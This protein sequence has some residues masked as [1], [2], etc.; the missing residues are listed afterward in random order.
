[1]SVKVFDILKWAREY[2]EKRNIGNADTD[3]KILLSEILGIPRL[4]LVLL[5]DEV[6]NKKTVLKFK[7]YI[8]RHAGYEPVAYI[9]GNAEFM[10]LK[11]ITTRQV[12]IPR[13][14]TEILAEEVIKKIKEKKLKKAAVLDIG[15][16]SGAVA[17]SVAAYVK[18]AKL[19]AVDK[20]ARALN[21]AAKNAAINGIKKSRIKFL[22]SDLFGA[23]KKTG[24]K[25][26][27]IVSNPPYIAE[28]EL[29]KLSLFVKKYEP[30]PALYGGKD[31]LDVIRK[32]IKGSCEYLKRGGCL[33]LETG[34]KQAGKV[35]K[36]IK[37]ENK[38]KDIEVI[39]DLAS[40]DRVIS[41]V[42]K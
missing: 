29:E 17:V 4:N 5:R 8:K 36:L 28:P 16:G 40:I 25:F 24:I 3:S 19:T 12:L 37:K 39:K 20:S 18:D 33:L 38:F 30:L 10:S 23:F 26:D 21:I 41:A 11:F 6:L 2:L 1:M 15:T 13:P 34:Y 7:E 14:E 27:I 42:K 31:G 22:K 32:I 9:L 35:V